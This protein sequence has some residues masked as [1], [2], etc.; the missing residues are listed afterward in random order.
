MQKSSPSRTSRPLGGGRRC[1]P[2]RQLRPPSGDQHPGDGAM[3]SRPSRRSITCPWRLSGSSGLRPRIW[4]PGGLGRQVYQIQISGKS[5]HAP[6][7]RDTWRGEDPGK[8]RTAL[9]AAVKPKGR[10]RVFRVTAVGQA[11]GG[12]RSLSR[13]HIPWLPGRQSSAPARPMTGPPGRQR[14][15]GR[16]RTASARNRR[17]G[18]DG[19]W[20]CC[21]DG[22]VSGL[23]LIPGTLAHARSDRGLRAPCTRR[24]YQRTCDDRWISDSEHGVA[25][26]P[27]RCW[28]SPIFNT[29][30]GP[31]RTGGC[32]KGGKS[33]IFRAFNR[34]RRGLTCWSNLEADSG[35]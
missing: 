25:E 11:G 19:C 29:A 20:T 13:P 23:S 2:R 32:W 30:G 12:G 26:V 22:R 16:N 5:A 33:P 35:P 34:R 1:A 4:A 18:A 17:T 3:A 27:T 7:P 15:R 8:R 14:Q 10:L 6:A 31:Q 9:K 28:K 24:P 21:R